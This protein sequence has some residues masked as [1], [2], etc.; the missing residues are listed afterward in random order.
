[1]LYQRRPVLQTG[2][3]I[4]VKHIIAD[5]V[6]GALACALPVLAAMVMA[7]RLAVLSVLPVGQRP[8]AVRTLYS[9]R[10]KSVLCHPCTLRRRLQSVPVPA[11]KPVADN[12]LLRVLHPHPFTLGLAYPPLVLKGNVG[13]PVMNGMADIGFVF[14]NALDLGY[15]PCVAFFLWRASIDIGKSPV[16]LEI[17]KSRCRYFFRNQYPCNAGRPFAVNSEVKNLLH[18]PAGF[19]V[20]YQLVLDFRVLLVP[21]GSIG[22]DTL[23]G[24]KLCLESGLY[25]AACIFRKPFIEQVFERDKIG[26]PFFSVSSFSAT[27]M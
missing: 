4:G 6:H 16:T 19:L 8:A 27:A 5:V 13:F 21:E 25:L 20:D 2:E 7:V 15:R 23:S 11:G 26:K 12:R 17:D 18:D 22:A 14:H 10:K 9:I 1:M 3:D 24:G